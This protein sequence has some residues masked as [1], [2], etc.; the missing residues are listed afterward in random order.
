MDAS[1]LAGALD[2]L[3]KSWVS[4][5]WW[6]NFWTILVAVGVAVE[7]F[8]IITEYVHD[9]RD[10]KRGT[11]RSPDRPNVLIFGLGFLGA[12]LVATGVAGEFQIHIK[13]GGI[14]TDMR[15]KTRQLVGLLNLEASN[16]NKKA[17]EANERAT[18]LEVNAKELQ[19]DLVLQGPRY[20]L[21]AGSAGERFKVA[22]RKFSGQKIDIK[23]V[24]GSNSN[25]EMQTF[26]TLLIADFLVSKWSPTQSP[27]SFVSPEVMI[28]RSSEATEATKSAATALAKALGDAGLSDV[29]GR[30][31]PPVE[32][33]S[34]GD[35]PP[36][37]TVW[38]LVGAHMLIKTSALDGSQR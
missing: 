36:P 32:V 18:Q 16:A 28:G 24:P 33:F 8:V 2:N 13:A 1:A 25:P 23:T 3:E 21:F 11:I 7:L 35:Q 6:L 12:A 9:R 26:I 38:L 30:I 37:D 34:V 29:N 15:D 4:L 22:L 5:D 27:Q 17:G 19:R 14:E 20:V 10:F 31:P